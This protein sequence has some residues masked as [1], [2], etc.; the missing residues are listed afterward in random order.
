MKGKLELITMLEYNM[1]AVNTIMTTSSNIIISVSNDKSIM[2]FDYNYR[3]I[4]KIENAHNGIIFDISLKDDNNFATCSQDKS[5]KTWRKSLNDKYLIDKVL[6]NI[7]D[8]DI[9]KIEYLKN[10]TII[11]GSKDMKIKIWNL[12]NN[13][14]KCTLVLNNNIPIYSLLYS[15]KENILISAGTMFTR[16]WD[17]SNLIN[18]LIS[19]IDVV[20]HGKNA[21]QKLDDN[22]VVFGGR[23]EI[24]IISIKEKQVSKKIK[25][26]FLVWAIC[27]I[28]NKQLFICG[29]VSNDLEIFSSINY[30]NLGLIKNCHN[31]N[32]RGISLL[33]NGKIITGSE[34]KKTK[35]WKI[36][37]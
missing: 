7:H 20:C 21:L 10:D 30:E 5:I 28:E 22:R 34:D 24:K 36:I 11:S 18:T 15:P 31:G 6:N 4:Q 32:L 14:Y 12:I 26:A 17:T 16:I 29:G 27:V 13:E 33:N 3:I 9:H 19:Q 8:N 1:D 25:S 37:I 35:I 2:L 23:F